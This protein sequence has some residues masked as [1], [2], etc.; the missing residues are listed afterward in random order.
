MRLG[1]FWELVEEAKIQELHS[2]HQK[3]V[4]L[5][6]LKA[7]HESKIMP[8]SLKIDLAQKLLVKAKKARLTMI[9]I[10]MFAFCFV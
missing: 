10:D 2:I 3:H 8:P 1:F 4:I 5:I 7:V 6:E 9:A